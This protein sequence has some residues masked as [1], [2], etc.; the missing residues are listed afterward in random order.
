MA[1]WESSKV[2]TVYSSVSEFGKP[3]RKM[4]VHDAQVKNIKTLENDDSGHRYVVLLFQNYIK[5]KLNNICTCC[6][7]FYWVL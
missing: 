1:Q 5:W 4:A 6:C 7:N 2:Y 3:K